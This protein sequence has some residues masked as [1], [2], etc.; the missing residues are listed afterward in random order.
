MQSVNHWAGPDR[1]FYEDDRNEDFAR[2][3]AAAAVAF[4]RKSQSDS[5][6]QKR[7]RKRG[8]RGESLFAEDPTN[9]RGHVNLGSKIIQQ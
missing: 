2:V 8:S 3:V 1:I 5:K 4:G 6:M 7:E 9:E